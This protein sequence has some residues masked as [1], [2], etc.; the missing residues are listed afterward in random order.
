MAVSNV[1]D[2]WTRP[3]KGPDGKLL[4]DDNGKIVRERNDR[5]GNGKRWL[6][7][8]EENGKRVSKA[9]T[10]KDAAEASVARITTNQTDGTHIN[11]DKAEVTMQEMWE[12]WIA[13]K[14]DRDPDTVTS[15]EGAWAK[16]SDT[17]GHRTCQ[18]ITGPEIA[19]FIPSITTTKG[20]PE[21]QTRP[22][23]SS[24]K[25]KVGIVLRG[26][27]ETAVDAGVVTKNPMKAK[28]VPK[29]ETA[30]RRYLTITEIDALY[31]RC[32]NPRD[33]DLIDL[34]LMTGCR[35]GE[36][37]AFDC[38]DLNVDRGRLRVR[39]AK[40]R[41]PR[42]LPVGRDLLKRLGVNARRGSG[43]LLLAPRGGRWT[44]TS[45]RRCW[46]RVGVA[47]LD[48]YELR[49]TAAS[50]AIAGGI[51]IKT[52][53]HMLG[54]KTA[55]MTLDLYGHFYEDRLDAAPAAIAGEMARLREV[56]KRRREGTGE[57]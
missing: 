29:Q 16:A 31:A 35:P 43:P 22:A 51:D 14:R 39:E 21:G 15:Y 1:R 7:T 34:L 9:F 55:A 41:E 20:C 54:H 36:A 25:R 19:A 33:Y 38:P 2:L 8:W 10:H 49:H 53:Q 11:R 50:L 46:E 45:L 4:R 42:D 40:N 28:S 27:L 6:A 23:G 47:D 56:E 30:D 5:W 17:F 24:L 52:L 37:A 26:V 18:S 48:M 32:T 12:L 3:S 57:G 13:S 44:P